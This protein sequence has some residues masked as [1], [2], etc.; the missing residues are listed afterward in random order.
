[1]VI[2]EVAE[3]AETDSSTKISIPLSPQTCKLLKLEPPTPKPVIQ[4]ILPAR[5]EEAAPS[6][7]GHVFIAPDPVTPITEDSESVPIIL[8]FDETSFIDNVED[9]SVNMR[10]L[11]SIP[12]MQKQ[13]KGIA[14]AVAER[15]I[16]QKV[17]TRMNA[18]IDIVKNK[19]VI[20][21]VNLLTIIRQK[22]ANL[23][24]LICRKSML[25]ICGKLAADN[26]LKVIEME[27]KS[28]N[29]TVKSIFF[30]EPNVSFDMRCWHSII[31]EQKIQNFIPFHRQTESSLPRTRLL[32]PIRSDFSLDSGSSITVDEFGPQSKRYEN[33]PKMMKLK[34][35]HEFLYYLIYAFPKDCKKIPINK[36]LEIWTKENPKIQ[37]YEAITENITNCYTTELSWKMF[38]SP[39]NPQLE[40]ESGWGLLRDI[41]HRIPLILFVKFTRAAQ[42]TAELNE[43]LMHPIKCNYLLHFLPG[44]LREQLLQ[45]RKYVFVIQEMC[46]KLCWCG[47]LQFGPSRTKEVDQSFIYLNQNATLLDTTSS[48]VGY[49]EISEQ[50]YPEIKF[51]FKSPEDVTEYWNKMFQIAINTRINKR[52][53]G[54]GKT[55]ELDKIY[56]KPELQ[57]AM[58][59]QTPVTAPL[60]DIGILPGDRKGAAGLDKAF[61][62]HLKRNWTR[63]LENEKGRKRRRRSSTSMPSIASKI[64]KTKIRRQRSTIVKEAAAKIKSKTISSV[65]AK[66]KG[67]S[68]QSKIIRKIDPIKRINRTKALSVQD[69]IDKEAL[70]LMKT[71]RVTWSELEDKTLIM[72]RVALKFAFTQ[73]TQ[74]THYV[75]ANVI[76]DIL[77]WRT[78]KALNKTSKACTRRI[79]YL[80][81]TKQMIKEQIAFYQEE[82]RTNHDFVMK[83]RNLVDRLKKIYPLEEVYNAIKIHIVEMVHRMHQIF[84]KQYLNNTLDVRNE[85]THD[86]PK[87]YKELTENY[88]I[89]NPIDTLIDQKYRDPKTTNEAEISMLMSLIHSAVC[90][91]HDKTS[92]SY[93]LFEV[94]KKFSDANLSAAV[95]QLKRATVITVNKNNKNRGKAILP[96]SFSPFH[97]SVRYGTQLMSVHVPVELYDEYFQAIKVISE[98]NGPYQLTNVNCGLIYMLAEMISSRKI[99]LSYDRADKLVMVDPALRKKSN[100]DQISENYMRMLKQDSNNDAPSEK[101]SVKFISEEANDE[102]FLYSDDPIEIFFKISQTYLHAFCFLKALKNGEE[103]QISDCKCTEESEMCSRNCVLHDDNTFAAE[104]RRIACQ[105]RDTVKKMLEDSNTEGD[106]KKVFT[107]ENFVSRFDDVVKKCWTEDINR[108]DF[109]GKVI[110]R[111]N[112]MSVKTLLVFI[113]KLST[114]PG[115]EED[116]W[117][118]DYKKLSEKTDDSVLDDEFDAT[119]DHIKLSKMLS[120]LKDLNVNARTSDSFVVN[121]ATI[122]VDVEGDPKQKELFDGTNL[123]SALLSF[124]E[125]ERASF[126]ERILA[127]AKWRREDLEEKNL[128]EELSA[129]G[130]TNTLDIMQI[131]EVCTFIES[132]AQMGAA[133]CELLQIFNDKNQLQKQIESLIKLKFVLKVGINEIKFVHKEFARF[134]L[135]DSFYMSRQKTDA[136]VN[137]IEPNNLKHKIT[138]KDC[139]EPSNKKARKDDMPSTSK[140]MVTEEEILIE[141]AEHDSTS[142]SLEVDETVQKAPLISVPIRIRPAPWLRV[143]GTLNRRVIDKWM[144]TILNHLTINPSMMLSELCIKFNILT[145]FDI[146]HLCEVLEM[147]GSIRLMT[148]SEPEFDLFS[149]YSGSTVGTL[150]NSNSFVDNV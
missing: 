67:I 108:K 132:K 85:L 92:Y 134:W 39:L 68:K 136:S 25:T 71:M 127:D 124:S 77:H 13:C 88:S 14:Q 42:G 19:T 144:G 80:M 76:R 49:L 48:E 97:L 93:H 69:A 17:L 22:E 122:Y 10:F 106:A 146:R 79:Q 41:I 90:C 103:I 5:Q 35:F 111:W 139:G 148:V 138:D 64:A 11:N 9:V 74:A 46:K 72:T 7:D 36:A 26:L 16:S 89:S 107:T 131:S 126:V 54:I 83:Y 82:L 147:I 15:K 32:T 81:K 37:E 55:L 110:S 113:K 43:Y 45:G 115:L 23:P 149:N 1:M 86:L 78:E 4:F 143:N 56:S 91:N 66:F 123:Q 101:K 137:S 94:Y 65:Q 121:L 30:G 6:A 40:Y 114:E 119:G 129:I 3:E 18:I 104:I 57:E 109:G 44:R 20:D 125:K 117:L 96:Y 70:K 87:N 58:K 34:L 118:S 61:L 62:A 141:L 142:K 21:Q 98:S 130:I 59:V 75:G 145:P 60:N 33:F 100:F 12:N 2:G 47:L 128:L 102:T 24:E 99:R 112:R 50:N 135:V 120:Q 140:S 29:K 116:S 8:P 53:A 38:V 105:G 31:E 51:H 84:Y 28:E 63:P 150:F 73:D 133:P 27:L 95:S 52:S